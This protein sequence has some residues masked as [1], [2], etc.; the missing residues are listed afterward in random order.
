MI[1]AMK[2]L[3]MNWF[4]IALVILG[5][6]ALCLWHTAIENERKWDFINCANTTNN[7]MNLGQTYYCKTLYYDLWY[8]PP[9]G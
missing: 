5:I 6:V 3:G 9:K 4:K 8:A 7:E 2:W 1:R